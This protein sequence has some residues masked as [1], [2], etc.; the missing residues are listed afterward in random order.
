[1]RETLTELE[2]AQGRRRGERE[3]REGYSG[4]DGAPQDMARINLPTLKGK[5]GSATILLFESGSQVSF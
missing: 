1:M 5:V 4:P 3:G 2:L